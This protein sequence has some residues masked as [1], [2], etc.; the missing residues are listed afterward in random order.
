[1][2]C[3][4]KLLAGVAPL[5]AAPVDQR[6]RLVVELQLDHSMTSYPAARA[7]SVAA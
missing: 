2:E 6:Q 7:A 1:V 3:A 5:V 4:I